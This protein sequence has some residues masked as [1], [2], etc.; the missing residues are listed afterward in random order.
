MDEEVH[1]FTKENLPPLTEWE[2]RAKPYAA[3]GSDPS[4]HDSSLHQEG[5]KKHHHH[6]KQDVAERAMDAEVHGFTAHNSSPV[7]E[8]R[9]SGL[10]HVPNGSDASAQDG[11]A[12]HQRKSKKHHKK[13]HRDVAERG[14]DEEVH[15]FTKENL[16]PLTEWERKTKPYAA[17]GSAPSAHDSSLGQHGHKH[18]HHHAKHDVAER[19]MDEEVHGF[20]AE[21]TSPV[22]EERRSEQPHV[23]NGSDATSHAEQGHKHSHHKRHHHGKKHENIGSDG[24]D[25]QVQGWTSSQ[26]V[27]EALPGIK[28]PT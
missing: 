24:I 19:K 14:M 22:A 16:P 27:I 15:G 28:K 3:N 9:R 12:L 7:A 26:N 21:Y 8:E 17:N 23:A 1:G 10:P 11:G 20:S 18:H 2:R 25:G 5:H 4:S 6:S 13:H